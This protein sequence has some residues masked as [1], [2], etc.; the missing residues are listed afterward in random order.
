MAD[1]RQ[2]G[3]HGVT[4]VYERSWRG[5]MRRVG[6]MGATVVLC[7]GAIGV[8]TAI[9]TKPAF[10][11]TAGTITTVAGD[12]DAPGPQLGSTM[13]LRPL[14]IAASG[15]NTYVADGMA[16]V[17][18]KL[19]SSGNET[20]V[21]GN[22]F[23]GDSGDGGPAT[24]AGLYDPSGIAVSASGNILISEGS[25]QRVRMVAATSGTFYGQAMTQGDIY[26]IAGNGGEGY[27]GDGGPAISAELYVPEGVVVDASGNVLIA[28]SFNDR[29]RV[30]AAITGT[31]YGQSMTSGDIYTI[32][33]NGTQGYSGDGSVATSAELYEPSGIG[34]DS[35]GNILIADYGN[36]RIRVVATATGTFYGRAMTK[37]DI[38]TI[39]GDGGEGYG[40]DG[41]VATSA[42][43][44]YPSGVA[45]DASG[46]ALI[47]DYFNNRIRV[48][49]TATGTFYGQSMT[50]GDIYTLAG[51]GSSGLGDGGPATSAEL[52]TPYSV[53]VDA[54]GDVLIADSDN[55]RLREVAASTGTLDGQ[56]MTKG[57]IY[58]VAGNGASSEYSGDSGPATSAQLSSPAGTAI[59]ASRQPPH[60]RRRQ[61]S[62]PGRGCQHGGLLWPGHDEGRHVHHRRWWLGQPG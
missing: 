34:V 14:G 26:T 44:D 32:A 9:G 15:G 11:S 6:G 61:R 24:L 45:V 35:S 58:T 39:A 48:V 25:G 53:V 27:S 33:G 62:D 7:S 59:D 31:F 38:Y 40:G 55:Y 50:K 22:G 4:R 12:F 28:D 8:L 19:D 49:A 16:S 20:I 46:N 10:A 5:R 21:A 37:G 60:R 42:P 43:L 57:D 51:G 17:V 1:W 13:A 54:S 52:S 2:G 56:P 36:L 30:V 3:A 47:A 18:R 23:A 41:G 29:L